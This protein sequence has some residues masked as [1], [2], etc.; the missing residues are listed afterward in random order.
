MMYIY[1][2]ISHRQ[3]RKEK[4]GKNVHLF[5][6]ALQIRMYQSHMV[7]AANDIPQSRQSLLYALDLDIVRKIIPQVLEFLVCGGRGHQEAFAVT[8]DVNSIP[9]SFPLGI[10][11][12]E[13]LQK[14]KEKHTQ[15]LT[16]QQ[17][18]SPR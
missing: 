11:N 8:V 17:C 9:F 12:T 4:R 3:Q 10:F 5:R 16:D 7:I 6:L 18:E 2:Y 1:I 14:E 13:Y 15:L